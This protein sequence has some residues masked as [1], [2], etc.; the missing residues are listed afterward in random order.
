MLLSMWLWYSMRYGISLEALQLIMVWT[1]AQGPD[2]CTFHPVCDSTGWFLPES[3]LRWTQGFKAVLFFFSHKMHHT[4]AQQS[5]VAILPCSQDSV[6]IGVMYCT[7][8]NKAFI[9]SYHCPAESHEDLLSF[10]SFRKSM[11]QCELTVWSVI[12]LPT[13]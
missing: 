2:T 3:W 8:L 6:C 9:K 11:L 10:L 1:P 12:F 4:H 7:T 5:A 13:V